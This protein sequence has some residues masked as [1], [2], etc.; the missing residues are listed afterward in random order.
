MRCQ[1][2][3]FVIASILQLL[4][5][6]NLESCLGGKVA[7]WRASYNGEAGLIQVVVDYAKYELGGALFSPASAEE[8]PSK[9]LELLRE[10]ID[11]D[12]HEFE[13]NLLE[14]EIS[15]DCQL[16]ERL[17]SKDVHFARVKNAM[18]QSYPALS[19]RILG[20]GYEP[21]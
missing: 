14:L 18:L 12:E 7:P 3:N 2:E 6:G 11:S 15:T 4:S 20:D 8:R 21:S 1:V 10:R 5:H 17:L 13:I 9:S 16:I 19:T